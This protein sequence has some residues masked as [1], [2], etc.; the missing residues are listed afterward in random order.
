MTEKE[1]IELY[2]ERTDFLVNVVG[3]KKSE[4]S[5]QGGIDIDLPS[6]EEWERNNLDFT[7]GD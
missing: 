3:L 2:K 4:I 5:Y 1:K 6:R 7:L